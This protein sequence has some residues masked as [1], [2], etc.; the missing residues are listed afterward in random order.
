MPSRLPRCNESAVGSN[1]QYTDSDPLKDASRSSS[2]F[3][4][5]SRS[6]RSFKTSTTSCPV[7]ARVTRLA[8]E[9]DTDA[10]CGILRDNA[11]LNAPTPQ[12]LA[13]VA[14]KQATPGRAARATYASAGRAMA[15]DARNRIAARCTR[16]PCDVRRG[17]GARGQSGASARQSSVRSTHNAL[18]GVG[19][20]HRWARRI[21]IRDTSTTRRG[22]GA[23]QGANRGGCHVPRQR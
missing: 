22:R 3:V 9:D 5:A 19:K 23:H 20:K 10:G 21:G 1:P 2:S 4:H 14:P 13:R 6:P 15:A 11:A 16:M 7:V 8:R 12:R 18:G 17:E